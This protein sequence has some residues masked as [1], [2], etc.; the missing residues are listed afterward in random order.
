MSKQ[1]ITLTVILHL[2][3]DWALDH[4]ISLPSPLSGGLSISD[5]GVTL[6][7]SRFCTGYKTSVVFW[8]CA[9]ISQ[10]ISTNYAD[11]YCWLQRSFFL[12]HGAIL[13]QQKHYANKKTVFTMMELVQKLSQTSPDSAKKAICQ[14]SCPV[15][16]R[17]MVGLLY[18]LR[19]LVAGGAP[20]ERVPLLRTQQP[21]LSEGRY[22]TAVF[23]TFPLKGHYRSGHALSLMRRRC[24]M[25]TCS[26]SPQTNG[27]LAPVPGWPRAPS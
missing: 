1:D 12:T 19:I 4:K 2:F 23:S 7:K 3:K 8:R 26:S 13:T 24:L 16:G 9:E 20:E 6:G 10:V 15:Q 17:K 5:N 27:H 14:F 22:E 18:L 21:Q 11:S 25:D